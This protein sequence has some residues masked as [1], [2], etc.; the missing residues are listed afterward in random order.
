MGVEEVVSS[1]LTASKRALA[2]P[3]RQ[4]LQKVSLLAQALSTTRVARLVFGDDAIRKYGRVDPISLEMRQ[5]KALASALAVPVK[6]RGI[7]KK[8]P[9]RKPQ[10]EKY[11]GDDSFP[12]S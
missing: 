10:A 7:D 9:Y 2:T 8:A 11:G 1:S 3:P 5:Q 4:T 6:K 12:L